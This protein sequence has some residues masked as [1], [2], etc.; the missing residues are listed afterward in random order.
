MF[1]GN[2]AKASKQNMKRR[3]ILSNRWDALRMKGIQQSNSVD[4]NN[5]EESSLDKRKKDLSIS[6]I[7]MNLNAWLFCSI[8]LEHT[9]EAL[10]CAH[11]EEL[12]HAINFASCNCF[13]SDYLNPCGGVLFGILV[14]NKKHMYC[15]TRMHK[16]ET[17]VNVTWS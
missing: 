17:H 10:L 16:T 3:G 5:E 14:L 9:F 1:Y 4:R 8:G 6:I 13:R 2:G 15:I 7:T 11:T 12:E